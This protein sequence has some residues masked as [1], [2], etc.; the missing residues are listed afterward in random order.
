MRSC[1]ATALARAGTRYTHCTVGP[2]V[3]HDSP[4]DLHTDVIA[5]PVRTPD[6]MCDFTRQRADFFIHM[7][8]LWRLKTFDVI[9]KNYWRVKFR[10][11]TLW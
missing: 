5:T 3:Q 6:Q 1:G 11:L 4:N 7:I 2:V 10:W 9:L 8:N